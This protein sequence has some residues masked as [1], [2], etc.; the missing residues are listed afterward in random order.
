MVQMELSCFAMSPFIYEI[1]V[2]EGLSYCRLQKKTRQ[3]MS[4]Q[5]LMLSKPRSFSINLVT[6][7]NPTTAE[8][9]S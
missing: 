2:K 3:L 9:I 1:I 7:E 5:D 6:W 8:N 4:L